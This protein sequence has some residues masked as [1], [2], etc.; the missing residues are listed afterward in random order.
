V[1]RDRHGRLKRAWHLLPG[2]RNEAL[3][4][5]CYAYAAAIEA[6]L[7]RRPAGAWAALEARLG[8]ALEENQAGSGAPPPVSRG[9]GPSRALAWAKPRMIRPSNP[10][11]D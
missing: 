6:G 2:R 7:W 10:Y 3:D 11:L 4:C 8:S 9:S 1:A 5:F